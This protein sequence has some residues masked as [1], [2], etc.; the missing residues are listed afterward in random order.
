M[1]DWCDCSSGRKWNQG[2][3]HPKFSSCCCVATTAA[4]AV[5]ASCTAQYVR[6]HR[7]QRST[8][9]WF[10]HQ[11]ITVNASMMML[12]LT[13]TL[14][15][16]FRGLFGAKNHHRLCLAERV[17]CSRRARWIIEPDRAG[18]LP[19]RTAAFVRHAFRNTCVSL[20][21]YYGLEIHLVADACSPCAFPF[22]SAPERISKI[23]VSKK[24]F[25]TAPWKI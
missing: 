23:P 5:W 7:S 13:V 16:I 11:S 22:F 24:K 15:D 12:S 21:D 18:H 8:P 1:A 3:H 2:K 6:A 4:P 25:D 9:L 20:S 17:S 14:T 19:K 10:T